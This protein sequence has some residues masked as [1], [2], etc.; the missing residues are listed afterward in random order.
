MGLLGEQWVPEARVKGIL[1]RM[2]GGN[3]SRSPLTQIPLCDLF[4][5]REELRFV[6]GTR[7]RITSV[8]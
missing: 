7:T 3:A 4:D 1:R 2:N 8:S 6:G 5:V